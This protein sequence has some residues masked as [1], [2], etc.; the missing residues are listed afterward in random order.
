[1]CV[2]H[3]KKAAATKKRVISRDTPDECDT[4]QRS[5]ND[6]PQDHPPGKEHGVLFFTEVCTITN[7]ATR[8]KAFPA[9]RRPAG[10]CSLLRQG[11]MDLKTAAIIKEGAVVDANIQPAADR[12]RGHKLS[13]GQYR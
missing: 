4:I 13:A 1:M 11:D 9:S 8:G 2:V 5:P 6:P 12:H 3:R 7:V 10:A